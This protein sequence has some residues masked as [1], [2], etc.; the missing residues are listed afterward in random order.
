VKYTIAAIL[1]V[2]AGLLWWIAKTGSGTDVVFMV[3]AIVSVTFFASLGNLWNSMYR[4]K[5]EERKAD[6]SHATV[7]R[8][9]GKGAPDGAGS[10]TPASPGA[11]ESRG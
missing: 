9:P 7:I 8:V 11:G 4:R 1:L 5:Q 2:S 3:V 10:V 6:L